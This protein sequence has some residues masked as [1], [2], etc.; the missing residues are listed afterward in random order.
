VADRAAAEEGRW[1]RYV[2][3]T[4]SRRRARAL[5][6]RLECTF[7]PFVPRPAQDPLDGLIMTILSQATNDR[8]SSLAFERLRARFQIWE[9][10]LESPAGEME[11]AIRP[12]GLSRNK[13]RA[14]RAV[15]AELRQR[16]TGFSLAHLGAAPLDDA[17]AELTALP[18]VGIK[19]AACVLLFCFGRPVMPVDT[20]VHRLSRRLGLVVDRATADQTHLVLMAVTP[21]ELVHPFHVWLIAQGRA[22]CHARSPCCGE[23]VLAD[24]CPAAF[25]LG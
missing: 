12:G 3:P 6:R 9:A 2:G 20:H 5:V 11:E 19:T 25:A 14:I 17:M 8:S 10:A 16:P 22:I 24:L 1:A 21:S 18:G 23:C 4:A 7:G 13:S 15:L